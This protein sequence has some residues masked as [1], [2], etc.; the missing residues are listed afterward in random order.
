MSDTDRNSNLSQRENRKKRRKRNQI[1]V[2]IVTGILLAAAVTGIFFG[3]RQIITMFQE[4]QKTEKEAEEM[5]SS[6]AVDQTI[7]EPV[8]EEETEALPDELDSL[9]DSNIAEMTLEEKVAGLFMVTPEAITGVGKVIQAGDGTKKAL[10]EY[11]VGG[12]VYFAQNIV[13]QEQ[14]KEMIS[15]TI[16]YS[17]Y[18]LFLGVDE[19]G[20]TVSRL[21]ENS[22]LGIEKVK[23]AGDIGAGGDPTEAYNAGAAIGT[24]LS[25]YGF[26]VDFAPVADILTNPNNKVIGSRSYSADADVVSSMV[27]SA[28]NGLQEKKVSAAVKHFPGIGDIETDPHKVLSVS[29]KSLEELREMELK[30]FT[31]GIEAG[32]DMIMVGHVSVP[33]ITGDN[34]PSSLSSLMVTDVLRSEMGFKGVVVT[35]AMNM[36]A[37]TEYYS[38]ADAAVKAIQAGVDLL[39]MPK[40][41]KAAYQGVLDAVA[42]G[43]ITEERIN[44]SLHRIF[45]IKYREA[46]NLS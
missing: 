2:Y 38:D 33:E 43:T 23:A 3:C 21:A 19:E 32:A 24:Y 11:P 29:E 41:F 27:Q 16:M 34:T 12:V 9:V 8:S 26:N 4:K 5:S 25:E 6:A 45:R 18:P 14:L 30:P 17:K 39:L 13:S 40:D 28:V 35:D 31:A 10:E 7:S 36:G 42:E 20:G 44:E 37:I 22:S 1:I 46:E 15:N